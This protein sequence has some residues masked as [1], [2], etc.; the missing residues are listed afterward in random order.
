MKSSEFLKILKNSKN[1][2]PSFETIKKEVT[3]KF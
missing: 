3:E 2:V 1:S